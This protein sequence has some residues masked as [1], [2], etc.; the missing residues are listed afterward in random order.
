MSIRLPSST[1]FGIPNI[2]TLADVTPTNS[3]C[4]VE[5]IADEDSVVASRLRQLGFVPGIEFEC[6]AVAPLMKNPYLVRIRGLS[7]ALAKHEAQ[8]IQIK[9]AHK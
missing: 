9:Q 2:M 6:V 4:I 3:Y 5:L 8:Q 1:A 7:I